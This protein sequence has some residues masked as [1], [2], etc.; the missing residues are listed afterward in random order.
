MSRGTV[1]WSG[2]PADAGQEIL[3]R[4]LGEEDAA[5]GAGESPAAL[6]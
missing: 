5:P 4:Y 6:S 3:D 2:T 1:G